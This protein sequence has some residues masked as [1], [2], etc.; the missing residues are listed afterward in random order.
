MTM[1]YAALALLVDRSGSM[2]G[3]ANDVVGSVKQF[4]DDQKK[5]GKASLTVAQFDHQYEVIYDFKDINEV[6]ADKFAKAYSPRGS[7]ALLDA[8]G[9]TALEMQKKLDSMAEA[10]RPKR[11]IVAVITDGLENAS[12]E[13]NIS[14]IKDLIQ[15]KEAAGWDFMFMGATLNT[16]KIAEGFGFS[17]NK[18]AVYSTKTF[19]TCMKTV[20]E[21]INLARLGKEM[22]F[23]Q[24]QRDDLM[25]GSATAA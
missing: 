16:I 7:T 12:T 6:D 10:D 25:K 8:I 19:D 20:G 2:H 4:I 17:S 5:T 11:V 9:R 14:Q 1:D 15:K 18:T 13:F 22:Q 21:Q 3:I 24:T 23:T